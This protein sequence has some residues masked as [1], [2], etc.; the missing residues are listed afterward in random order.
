MSFE[1]KLSGFANQ[2]H[3]TR[4][5]LWVISKSFIIA[6]HSRPIFDNIPGSTPAKVENSGGTVEQGATKGH[7]AGRRLINTVIVN[8]RE[9]YAQNGAIFQRRAPKAVFLK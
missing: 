3:S 8:S 4:S 9:I 1:Q 7:K 6:F 2:S 5:T